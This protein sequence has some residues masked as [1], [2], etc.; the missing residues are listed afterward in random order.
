MIPFAIAG[1]QMPVTALKNNIDAMRRQLSVLVDRFPWVQ[2][3]VFSELAAFGPVPVNVQPLPGPIEE[4]FCEM[5][6]QHGLWLIPG[7]VFERDGDAMYNTSMVI[8]PSGNVVGRHRKLFPFT[9]YEQGVTPG[10]DFL[11]FD[12]PNAGRFGL[13]IC[14][15]MWFPETTRTLTSMG[16]E[17]IIHPSL[18]NSIDREV[19]HSI[20]MATSAMN[21]CYMVDVNGLGDGGYGQS[22]ITGPDGR[23]I[24]L[25]SSHAQIIPFE[26]DFA[27]VRRE[28]ETGMRGL[29]QPLKSFRDRRV[30]FTVYN[31][32]VFDGSYL[33]SLGK[34][35]KPHRG[36]RAGIEETQSAQSVEGIEKTT[37]THI[38]EGVIKFGGVEK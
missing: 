1:I 27:A 34:L 20:C 37:E 11:V 26:V 13:S 35:Q 7:S 21:Q 24:H 4:T 8:D 14:Y 6:A 17:V 25:A 32:D 5:A 15:D 36:S 18:T 23:I 9:P 3:A 33:H 16:A 12:V 31:Q 19:E 28:R 10:K 38:H 30:D 29:G 22:I 2:M